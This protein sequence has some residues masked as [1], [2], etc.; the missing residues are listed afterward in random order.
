MPAVAAVNAEAALPF[1]MPDM[2][3]TPEPPAVTGKVPVVKALV[4]V[5]Y[6]APPEVNDVKAVPPAVVGKVPVVN[7]EV[8]VA[9]IAPPE[10]NEVRFVPPLVVAKVPAKVIAPDVAEDGVKPVVP[11]ENVVTGADVALDANNL[12]TPP[13][14]L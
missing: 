8:D 4:E 7:T 2:E 6:I 1:K 5:A 9:Y 14:S 3:V 10:V 12:T 13:L 11:A